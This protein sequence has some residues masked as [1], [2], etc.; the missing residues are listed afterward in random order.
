MQFKFLF[1]NL[2]AVRYRKNSMFVFF[3][4]NASFVEF[5]FCMQSF[6]FFFGQY[7]GCLHF[8]VAH[9]SGKGAETKKAN[10][11]Y[12]TGNSSITFEKIG[13]SPLNLTGKA[14]T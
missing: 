13:D 7:N 2:A 3:P 11:G 5:Y 8:P 1:V 14:K 9:F 6:S 10:I 12:T 4:T